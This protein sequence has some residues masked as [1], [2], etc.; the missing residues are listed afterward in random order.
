MQRVLAGVHYG[1]WVNI[2]WEINHVSVGSIAT[3]Y[4]K[5]INKL[6]ERGQV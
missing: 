2:L 5:R 4:G 3:S 6:W 1:Q